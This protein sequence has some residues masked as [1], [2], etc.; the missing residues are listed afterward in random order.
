[1]KKYLLMFILGL[2]FGVQSLVLAAEEHAQKNC[3]QNKSFCA[4]QM[5]KQKEDNVK[6]RP[7][8]EDDLN[9]DAKQRQKLKEIRAAKEREIAPL[10]DQIKALK[11]EIRVIKLTR[12][13]PQMQ[14][15]KIARVEMDIDRVNKKILSIK[16]RR[17]KEFESIL[18]K[19]QKQQYKKI[20][21]KY[22]QPKN[23]KE[24]VKVKQDIKK[25]YEKK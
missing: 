10:N 25:T 21:K 1:M 16:Q 15:E 18:T 20:S 5:T 13:A 3:D 7:S 11:D 17:Q 9:L 4:M 8:L 23:K 6:S 24:A 19:E 14:K 2:S 22:S 12:I